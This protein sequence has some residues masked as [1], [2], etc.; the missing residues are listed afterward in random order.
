[1]TEFWQGGRSAGI[2]VE[3]FVEGRR[4][5]V[6]DGWFVLIFEL[7]FEFTFELIIELPDGG[8]DG[9]VDN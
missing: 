5:D 8:R 6:L 3:G 2:G 1:M 4:V 7:T 9:G